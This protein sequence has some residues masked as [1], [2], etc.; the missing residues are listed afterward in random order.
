MLGTCRQI[1]GAER[2]VLGRGGWRGHEN[3]PRCAMAFASSEE[4]DECC[5]STIDMT[6]PRFTLPTGPRHTSVTA[7]RAKPRHIVG[8]GRPPRWV[9]TDSLQK[10]G[11]RVRSCFHR[12]DD[13]PA[14]WRRRSSLPG[15]ARRH[16]TEQ[17]LRTRTQAAMRIRQ[18]A[19]DCQASV[20]A[21][22]SVRVRVGSGATSTRRQFPGAEWLDERAQRLGYQ[23]AVFTV[24]FCRRP[25][26]RASQA[27]SPE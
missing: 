27:R 13:V 9:R 6:A 17:G 1:G 8:G 24:T 18:W 19:A 5:R 16:E 2:C 4:M 10:S 21:L 20:E 22:A 15:R 7:C 26:Q 23:S 11:I 12:A 14:L 3:D 25:F